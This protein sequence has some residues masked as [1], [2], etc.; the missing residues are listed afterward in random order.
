MKKENMANNKRIAKNTMFLYFRMM[1]IMGVSLYTSRVVLKTLGI[2]DFG[3]YNV[4]GGIVTMFTFLNGSLGAATSRYI[5][6]ELGKKNYE[7]LNQVFNVAFLIHLLIGVLVILLAETI[8]L[9]F[10][11]EKMTIPEYR[12][13]AAFWVYQ[14]S[15]LT[16]F[17]TLTQVPYNATII[18]HENMK[19]YAWV[20][21]VEVLCKL[22]VVYLLIISPFD[23]LVFYAALLCLIQVSIIFFYRIYCSRNCKESSLKL[24][25]DKGLYKEMFGYAG[26]DLIGNISV[27]A[28][29]QGLNLLLNVFFGPVVNAARGVA[30]Q[31]QGAVTQFSNNFMTA[32]RPQIIKSYAQGDVKGM[33]KLVVNSSCFSYYLMWMISFPIMLEADYILKLWLG[34]YPEHT[35]SFLNLVLVLCLIQTLKTPR[36]TVFHATGHLK[37]INMAIG[38]IL[39][40]AFPLAYLFLKLGMAPEAVFWAA[41]ITMFVSEIAS[42]LILKK[43]VTYSISSYLFHVHGRCLMIS[44]VSAIIPFLFFDK[45]MEPSF[46]RLLLTG[47]MTTIF[48]AVSVLTLGMDKEMRKKLMTLI[49]NKIK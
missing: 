26:S 20:G 1:L 47:V 16:C 48:I 19:I 17:F 46:V 24:Y 33:M 5:T 29:G 38:G 49:S 44:C 40:A 42:I 3:I 36:T 25:K 30:Y 28:Q 8:G 12:M 35:V 34:K 45:F 37:L 22:L 10:F 23:K 4:V 21:I 11:Y 7:R 6:F 15:I 32:V 31:V 41:N 43:Y 9:W 39:C 18:A 14:I 13:F 27:L 2:E